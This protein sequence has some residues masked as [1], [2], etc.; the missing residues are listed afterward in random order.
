M[1]KC[2]PFLFS[3]LTLISL[4]AQDTFSIVAVDSITG[5]VGSAGASCVDLFQAGLSSDHFL[6]Q[7]I[8]GVGAINTQAYYLTANQNNATTQMNQGLTPTQIIEWLVANDAQGQPALRQYGIAAL[9]NG[10]PQADAYTGTSTN[11]Y[12]NHIIGPNYTIQGNI[13]LGQQVLDSMEARFLRE[14]GDLACKLMAAL[15]GA[16]MVGADTR[17][18]A[19][20][21]S[22]LFAFVKVAQTTDLFDS[23]SF[24]ASVRTANNAG[25]EPI[26]SLQIKFNQVHS[27]ALN[28][29]SD[30][31]DN[32]NY[33][34]ISPNPAEDFIVL[35]CKNETLKNMSYK[36]YD[37]FNQ[38]VD[39]SHFVESKKIDLSNLA[40]GAYFI[41]IS[42]NGNITTKKIIKK[43]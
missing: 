15:Q 34:S 17:C 41:A 35:E 2:L 4:K 29:L 30:N 32:P 37:L 13:L 14:D 28:S 25:I 39:E 18:T 8:P 5:E 1:K 42:Y 36:I 21:T 16:N 10:S 7:L 11:D 19:N 43:N 20:G 31:W 40:S 6:G 26:D 33:F 38:V 27:C 23:P 12:K 3:C 22:S 9:I 24:V